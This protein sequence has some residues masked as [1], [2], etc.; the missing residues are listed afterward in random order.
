ML[1]KKIPLKKLVEE[2]KSQS[3]RWIKTKG[4]L[5]KN[6]HWQDGYGA[7]SVDPARTNSMIFY[8]S[9]QQQHHRKKTFKEEFTAFLKD[10]NVEY[11]DRYVWD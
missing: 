11:D 8:I 2:L 1:S 9:N 3:S 10:N 6:F 4:G 7:F 5:Y